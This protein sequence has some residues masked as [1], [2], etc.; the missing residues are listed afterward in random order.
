MEDGGGYAVVGGELFDL[1]GG[2]LDDDVAGYEAGGIG[3][4]SLVKGVDG[5]SD[6]GVWHSFGG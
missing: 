2:A 4:V 3:A 5:G 6:L 1:G